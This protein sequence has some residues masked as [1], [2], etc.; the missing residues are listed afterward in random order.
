ME[1]VYK[2]TKMRTD[3]VGGINYGDDPEVAQMYMY[4]RTVYLQLMLN[5]AYPE[6]RGVADEIVTMDKTLERLKEFGSVNLHAVNV[7]I[8]KQILTAFPECENM[9]RK[10]EYVDLNTYVDEAKAGMH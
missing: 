3:A 9:L 8:V 10:Y 1:Y 2:P 7:S 6:P 5:F 4:E